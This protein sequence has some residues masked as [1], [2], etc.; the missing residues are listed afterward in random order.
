MVSLSVDLARLP[1][2]P[3]LTPSGSQYPLIEQYS[4]EAQRRGNWTP[5]L[6]AF[7]GVGKSS[8]LGWLPGG[9]GHSPSQ[10]HNRQ[11]GIPLYFA[12]TNKLISRSHSDS[13]WTNHFRLMGTIGESISRGAEMHKQVLSPHRVIFYFYFPNWICFR[14]QRKQWKS[15][16]CGGWYLYLHVI[17]I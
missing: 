6:W 10:V 15:C 4:V 3:K 17:C 8:D 2:I 9:G 1:S 12:I 5:L 16:P 14:S 13:A 7:G 11:R